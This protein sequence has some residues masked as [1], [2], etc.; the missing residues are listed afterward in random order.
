MDRRYEEYCL[1]DPLFYDAPETARSDDLEFEIARNPVPEKWRRLEEG[2]WL[3]YRPDE[4]QLPAQGW[5]IHI[6]A[7]SD[8]ADN[9]LYAVWAYCVPRRLT[10]KF[11]SGRHILLMHN[12]KYAARGSSGKLVTIY[13]ADEAELE[14]T[15]KELGGVLEGQPGPYILS[16]LRFG[17]GPLYVRYG[18]FV[19]RRCLSDK[20]DLVL[21]I[22][23]DTGQLVPDR[24]GP[25]FAVPPWVA[26]PG[27]LEPHLAARNSVTVEG[28]PYRIDRVLHFSNGGGLYAAE[29]VRTGDRVV[30]KEAR[31]YAGLAV[32]GSDAVAR[33][34][35]ERTILERLAGLDA[36]PQTCDSFVLGEHHFLVL[37]FLDGNPLNTVVGQRYPLAGEDASESAVAAYTSWALDVHRR[38]EA[39]V[40]SLHGRGVV[41]GDLHPY[42][43]VVRPD[44]RVALIDFE[45]ASHVSEGRRPT[46]AHPGFAAPP[47][48]VGFDIDLYALACL[49]LSLFLPLTDLL[50]LD[51]GRARHLAAEIAATFP[52][53]D[54]F[55][56]DAVRVIAGGNRRATG[57][58]P[59]ARERLAAGD[60][61]AAGW[62]PPAGQREPAARRRGA[63]LPRLTPDAPGWRRAR[64]AITRA[65][66]A[67]A[68]PRR[69]DRL[70]PGDIE[71]FDT[72]GLDIA[73]GASGVLYALSV[74][75]AGRFPDHEDWLIRRAGDPDR[76]A[77]LGFYD[78]LHGV[79]YVLDHLGYRAAA[80]HL[81]DLCMGER[82][83]R[84]GLDLL[85]GLAGIGL[86]LAHLAAATGDAA[87]N[88]AAL[89]AADL[90]A[91]R[92]GDEHSVP[93]VSGGDHPTAGLLHGSSG[94]ALLFLRLYERTGERG[95]LDLA[96]TALRQDLRRCVRQDDG[97][98]Q[99][100]EG[101]RTMP[102]LAGGSVGIGL[103]VDRYLLHRDDDSFAEASAAIR[104]AARA[105]FYVQPGLFSGLAGMIA[106]L[107]DRGDA[108]AADQVR[109]L[110]RHAI[111]YQTGLAFPGE[112]LLRLSMDLATGSAGV[113]L[114][115]GAALHR[116]PVRLPFLVAET[117]REVKRDGT[118]RP[119]RDGA[120]CRG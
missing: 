84:L 3:V 90:V 107:A 97:S 71:Q 80:L 35:R 42:N 5:K 120:P 45:V 66:L 2:D 41:F 30:L 31:P 12:S 103:V 119:A 40:A 110:S 113:L 87:L 27:F 57:N 46:L 114:A 78:G 88:D 104:R 101:W 4:V 34:R 112:Q 116:E 94:P 75:G 21:A 68:T 33:L 98:L 79:A 58:R 61:R 106:Y 91:G 117:G 64:A 28:L 23:D 20:G 19:E 29:D 47:D 81:V 8:N 111:R 13:P 14:L 22:E 18:G 65:I 32:D 9:I 67:S 108:A 105:R 60:R 70:F 1:V 43:I 24:R 53:P 92:L 93:T 100:D 62:R 76:R 85:G 51:P 38:V 96:A 82:W 109:R 54:G 55:L 15:L 63:T 36:V 77:R 69:D 99:V 95:Y 7:C 73:Y 115:L 25:T 49:R 118:A 10:F 102:Y 6:S 16:D 37:E 86:N 11:L 56:G 48:R 72:G 52:V 44:D 50:R 39:A 89:R 26:L 59:A 83:E 74:T 17:A